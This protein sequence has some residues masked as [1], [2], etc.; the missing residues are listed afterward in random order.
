MPDQISDHTSKKSYET[1]DVAFRLFA[2]FALGFICTLFI[3]LLGVSLFTKVLTRPGS[4]FGRVEHSPEKSLAAFPHPQLQSDPAADLHKYLIAKERELTSYGWINEKAGIVRIP[5]DRSIDLLISR[6]VR[7]RPS[8][9]GLTELDM[10][11]QKAG[12]EKIM[13]PNAS[14]GRNP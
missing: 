12:A 5:I 6:G 14:Q 2:W 13:P 11:T 10:Q 7:V 3:I 1:Q 9:S 4:V 8:D